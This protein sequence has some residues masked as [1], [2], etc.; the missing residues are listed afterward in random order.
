MDRRIS[1]T[2][3]GS[4]LLKNLTLHKLLFFLQKLRLRHRRGL[5]E[6]DEVVASKQKTSPHHTGE[7]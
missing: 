7:A 5:R 2:S 6:H 1:F 3:K 4:A